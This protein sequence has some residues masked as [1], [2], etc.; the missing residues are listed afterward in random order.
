MG[1]AGK[2]PGVLAR[3]KRAHDPDAPTDAVTTLARVGVEGR[4][5]PR[6][7][8]NLM[9][10]PNEML[11]LIYE[12]LIKIDPATALGSLPGVDRRLRSL[13]SG[14]HGTFAKAQGLEEIQKRPEAIRGMLKAA[15]KRFPRMRDRDQLSTYPLHDMS[16]LGLA[17]E[18]ATLLEEKAHDINQLVKQRRV[19]NPRN[20][21]D[22]ATNRNPLNRIM[23][24]PLMEAIVGNNLGTVQV[25][26]DNGADPNVDDG[27]FR[28]IN[29]VCQIQGADL[30]IVRELLSA[31]GPPRVPVD[32]ND[33]P[34]GVSSLITSVGYGNVELAQILLDHGIDVT[35]ISLFRVYNAPEEKRPTLFRMLLPKVA[36]GELV[37]FLR[38]VINRRFPCRIILETGKEIITPEIIRQVFPYACANWYATDAVT[39]MLDNGAD[40]NAADEYGRTPLMCAAQAGLR[41]ICELLVHRGADISAKTKPMTAYDFFTTSND[42]AAMESDEMAFLDPARG[43]VP[44]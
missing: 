2:R 4:P 24:T 12:W 1:D 21:G 37:S 22:A 42:F 25:L 36:P 9:E 18:V 43:G 31:K 38:E 6:I 3:R 16:R 8:I 27:L 34:L 40:P 15:V 23:Y 41:H 13:T 28:I 44:G 26:L 11:L 29:I 10:L 39:A 19:K 20:P 14:V 33:A 17:S 7:K 35:E 32:V 30:N 5:V